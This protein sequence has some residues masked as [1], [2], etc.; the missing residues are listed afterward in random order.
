[1]VV[2]ALIGVRTGHYNEHVKSH[3]GPLLEKKGVNHS[4]RTY[5]QHHQQAEHR[6]KTTPTTTNLY[7]SLSPF[8]L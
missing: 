3:D 4:S 1:M 5:Q 6:S 2:I 7:L 8:F